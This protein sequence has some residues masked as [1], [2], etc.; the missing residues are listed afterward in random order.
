MNI[1]L[2]KG[3][4]NYFNRILKKEAS[5]AAYKSAVAKGDYLNYLDIMNVNFNPNDGVTTELIIGKGELLWEGR[6]D[7]TSTSREGPYSPDYCIAYE[8]VDSN[9]VINSRWFVLECER[10]RGGQYRIALKRDVL[11]DYE[12]D[13]MSAPCFIEKGTITDASDPLLFNSEGMSFNQIKKDE[14]PLKDETK[15]AWLVGYL[16]KDITTPPHVTYTPADAMDDTV[17]IDSFDWYS[18]ITYRDIDG[19][20]TQ[21][22]KTFFHMNPDTSNFCWKMQV[23]GNSWPTYVDTAIKLRWD[24]RGQNRGYSYDIWNGDYQGMSQEA[25]IIHAPG[26]WSMGIDSPYCKKWTDEIINKMLG[27]HWDLFAALKND[28]ISQLSSYVVSDNINNILNYNGKYF[29]KAD[30]VYKLTIGP[31][32][33]I[34]PSVQ[35]N[36][37]STVANALWNCVLPDSRNT[38]NGTMT[39]A[40]AT[41][42]PTKPRAKFI[43]QGLEYSI[44]AQEVLLP[45][46][47]DFTLSA[48]SSRNNV[49][50]AVYNMFAMPVMPEALGITSEVNRDRAR[51]KIAN[52]STQL[53]IDA[54]SRNN[55]AVATELCTALGGNS[56]ASSI[57]DLQ[58]LPYCPMTLPVTGTS[59]DISGLTV[60]KDYQYIQNTSNAIKGIIFFPDRANFSKNIDL[61]I[62]NE[63]I[64]YNTVRTFTNPTFTTLV[65]NWPNQGDIARDEEGNPMLWWTCPLRSANAYDDPAVYDALQTFPTGMLEDAA[66]DGVGFNLIVSNTTGEVT[67]YFSYDRNKTLVNSKTYTGDMTIQLDW[68]I[69]DNNMVNSDGALDIKVKNECDFE[70]IVSPNFNGMFEFK[71][72]RLTDGIHY[73]NID[74]TYKPFIPYIK[75]NPDFSGLYGQDWNDSTGLICGGDFSIPMM[76]DAFV[77]Y[78]LQNKNFQNIFNRQIENLD[79]NQQIAKEQQQFQGIFGAITGGVGG[80]VGGALAGA[81]AGPYGAIAGAVAGGVGGTAAGIIGYNKD[82]DWL[83]RAQGET[84]QY[85]IDQFNY[86]LGNIK[87]IPQSMTKSSPLSFNNKVW[88]IL[89]FFSCTDREKEVL[90]NKLKYDGMTIMAVGTIADYLAT[91]GYVKGKLIRLPELI[92]DFHVADAIYQEVDKGFYEGE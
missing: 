3:Y 14:L 24:L 2:L 37:Q 41:A 7:S 26:W 88:P 32:N 82:K 43:F 71:K 39:L 46:T 75:L 36:G 12:S 74:C 83:E 19:T 1:L 55:L 29:R 28:A 44:V 58:L 38:E 33:A 72:C 51:M 48:E 59:I 47:I 10:T 13:I 4:N 6:A 77:N 78:E 20:V 76:N 30:K 15:C 21:G 81:K 65:T 25:M 45:G 90:K 5:L 60:N 70:R 18:C 67:V 62:P 68:I 42:N 50:D 57:Y 89:E 53:Y 49:E 85:S 52:G 64:E 34:S 11:V 80:A 69:P 27:Q 56:S 79:I 87:A 35:Y 86:Q 61:T 8:S 9:T 54:M 23:P 66:P 17:S 22:T 31:G 63:H 16:K 84:R 40:V 73:I 91:G 92:D